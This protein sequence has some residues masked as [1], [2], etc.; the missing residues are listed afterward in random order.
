MNIIKENAKKANKD[1][2]N[3]R[4][5]LL[6]Y[7]DILESNAQKSNNDGSQFPMRDTIDQIGKI[8]KKSKDI[9]IDH[10]IFGYNFSTLDRDINKMIEITKQFSKF[11]K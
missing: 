7:P 1:P 3:F 10:L 4:V 5:I 8:W 6:T 11:A 2:N 9:M